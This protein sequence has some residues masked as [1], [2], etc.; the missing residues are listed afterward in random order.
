MC[1]FEKSFSTCVTVFTL[2]VPNMSLKRD[3]AYVA[4]KHLLL[5][6]IKH[7]LH[8]ILNSKWLAGCSSS[9]FFLAS[10]TLLDDRL[11]VVDLFNTA[12]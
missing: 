7:R 12:N 10:W 9:Q 8:W 3:Q 11:K 5:S 4:Y 1:A 6:L 2:F